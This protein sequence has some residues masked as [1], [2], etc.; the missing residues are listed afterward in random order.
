MEILKPGFPQQLGKASPTT[1]GFP[2][3]PHRSGDD[4]HQLNLLT[5]GVGQIRR[6]KV[7]HTGWTKP[8]WECPLGRDDWKVPTAE[9]DDTVRE[10]F[11]QYQV[12]R[13]YADPP[14]WQSWV[15]AWAGEFGE[16]IVVEWWTNRRKAMCYALE[17]FSSAIGGK[18][19]S[20]S[21]DERLTRHVG[22]CHKREVGERDD[23]GR[24]LWLIHKERFDSPRKID[25]AMAAVLSWEARLDAV[26]AGALTGGGGWS[27]PLEDDAGGRMSPPEEL[28]E[29]VEDDFIPI[30]GPDG[31]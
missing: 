16:K 28:E 3:S 25:L 11:G 14:Y 13:M 9:V 19:V 8:L 31:F 6:S 7:G 12:V 4:H 5:E 27:L 23:K 18:E 22:N 29:D 15:A 20:Q 26:A 1:L 24:R 30:G 10:L 17:A 21:G 2:T